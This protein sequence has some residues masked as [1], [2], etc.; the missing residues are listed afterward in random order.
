[1]EF[2][3]GFGQN[4]QINHFGRPIL[5]H[6]WEQPPKFATQICAMTAQRINHPA[7]NAMLGVNI[8]VA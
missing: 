5:A 8:S 4:W 7:S 1:M 3:A 6:I 2:E